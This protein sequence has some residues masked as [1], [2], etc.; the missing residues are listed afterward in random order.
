VDVKREQ[1]V[2]ARDAVFFFPASIEYVP[3]DGVVLAIS[4]ATGNWL[5]LEEPNDVAWVDQLRAGLTVGK[6][7]DGIADAAA[8]QRAIRL[9]TQV[10]AREFAA[11]DK[12][13]AL[14]V[15]NPRDSM[16][17][18]LTNACNLK[19]SHCYMYSGKPLPNELSV[20]EW[21][22]VL[23]EFRG[24]GG[25]AVTFSGGEV[26]TKRDWLRALLHAR[27]L[28]LKVT[29]LTNGTLWTQEDIEAAAPTLDEVQISIDGPSELSNALVRGKG[30]FDPSVR[31]ALAFAAHG[32]RTSVAMTPTLDNLDSF[33]KEFESFAE[34]ILARA[35]GPLFLKIGEKL[36]VGRHGDALEGEPAHRYDTVTRG[37][38]DKIYPEA[39]VRNFAMGHA[40]N[41]G[42]R[43][44]GFGG[45]ALAA[46]GGAFPCNRVSEVDG[47][48][49]VRSDG[50][51]TVLD[52]VL[53]LQEETSVDHVE[54]CR[55]CEIR[56][57]C[58]G[59]CRIEEFS[60]KGRIHS[61]ASDGAL[62]QLGK[63]RADAMDERVPGGGGNGPERAIHQVTCDKSRKDSLYRQ[64]VASTRYL[65]SFGP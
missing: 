51:R 48:G 28:G 31:T 44:C 62:V 3:F 5:V 11:A 14:V 2:V 32:V 20:D 13:P 33:G 52:R 4:P 53:R 42:L 49:N 54:P 27:A 40:P 6:L 56:Y 39:Q 61:P 63:R 16:H 23:D 43:N 9:V 50:L 8:R 30:N 38:S 12:P 21:I 25:T 7:L 47:E 19:C 1:R 10:T 17:V 24:A 26:T 58:G 64:M 46:D 37:A 22:G 34:D 15:E 55:T 36:I 41:H 29:L 45:L 60:F 18:Y 35:T 59:G 65:Y 57:V